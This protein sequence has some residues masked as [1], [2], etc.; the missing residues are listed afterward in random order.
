MVEMMKPVETPHPTTIQIGGSV[1]TLPTTGLDPTPHN[2]C[3]V[4]RETAV[5]WQRQR[6][7][8][9]DDL[10]LQVSWAENLVHVGEFSSTGQALESAEV[11][12]N[13]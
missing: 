1:R 10:D 5:T 9:R 7:R 8:G 3:T 4:Q 13:T 12:P 11:S 2:L 6:R